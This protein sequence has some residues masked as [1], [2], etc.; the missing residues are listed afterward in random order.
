MKNRKNNIQ[1]QNKKQSGFS[2][3]EFVLVLAAVVSITALII[4]SG[5]K[6]F[7]QGAKTQVITDTSV[8][9]P[10]AVAICS[11]IHKGDLS[12]CSKES[13]LR[14]SQTL[15]EKTV[16]GDNWTIVASADEVVLTYP[17]VSCADKDDIGNEVVEYVGQ[18]PRIDTSTS[19]T[20]YTSPNIKITYLR[21]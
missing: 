21:K 6:L 19:K 17:L 1:I 4:F 12:K 5:T 14:K 16:C 11:R 9:I 15:E 3:I 7:G 13:L 18:L 10:S 8:T 2:I 20:N